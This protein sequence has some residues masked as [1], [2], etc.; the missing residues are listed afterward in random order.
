MIWFILY[1]I[2][3]IVSFVLQPY[4]EGR[5]NP[6]SKTSGFDASAIPLHVFWFFFTPLFLA[7]LLYERLENCWNNP[8][9]NL[10]SLGQKHSRNKTDT[11]KLVKENERLRKKLGIKD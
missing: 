3:V 2:G 5:M 4:L 9:H 7:I 1:V 6:D 10:Y 11:N 8:H